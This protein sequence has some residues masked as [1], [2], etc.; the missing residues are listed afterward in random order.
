[1][2]YAV[3]LALLGTTSSIQINTTPTQNREIYE[4]H[5]R[6][7]NEVVENQASTEK[8][9]TDKVE[10]ENK[11]NSA[12]VAEKK[13]EIEA[14]RYEAMTGNVSKLHQINPDAKSNATDVVDQQEATEKEIVKA[15][16]DA[17]NTACAKAQ[18]EKDRVSKARNIAMNGGVALGT[19]DPEA[20]KKATEIVETQ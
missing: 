9:L 8:R 12:R 15:I 10:Q 20:K 11:E 1:M 13:A 17:N 5:K 4:D 6:L 19:I 14:Q 7:A 16:V 3:L 18:A 2:K